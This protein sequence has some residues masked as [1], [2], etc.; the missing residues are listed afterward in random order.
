MYTGYL[1]IQFGLLQVSARDWIHHG[2]DDSV[3]ADPATANRHSGFCACVLGAQFECS[4]GFSDDAG[5]VVMGLVL[6]VVMV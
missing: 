5:M 3:G 4:D 6:S 1:I 2:Q